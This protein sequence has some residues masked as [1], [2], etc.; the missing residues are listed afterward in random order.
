MPQYWY[1]LHFS[2]TN[3]PYYHAGDLLDDLRRHLPQY[4]NQQKQYTRLREQTDDATERAERLYAGH[5][6]RER[7]SYPNPSTQVQ[8]LVRRLLTTE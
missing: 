7:D 8:R 6:D 1:L 3:R 4:E 2:E 5:P